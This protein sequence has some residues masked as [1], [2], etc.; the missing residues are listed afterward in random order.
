[1]IQFPRP[2]SPGPAALVCLFVLAFK[3]YAAAEP[4]ASCII[5][6]VHTEISVP[7]STLDR[8]RTELYLAVARH[9]GLL[10][11]SLINT[12]MLLQRKRYIPTIYSSYETAAAEAGRLLKV[13]Y[14]IYAKLRQ[15]DQ[16]WVFETGLLDVKQR[17]VVRHMRGRYT[18]SLDAFIREAPRINVEQLLN[19]DDLFAANE[20]A[21]A[22]KTATQKK[23]TPSVQSHYIEQKTQKSFTMPRMTLPDIAWEEWILNINS[24]FAGRVEAGLRLINQR[25]TDNHSRSFIGS[26]D[27]LPERHPEWHPLLFINLLMQPWLG[28]ELSLNNRL[29]AATITTADG[30]SDGKVCVKGPALSLFVRKHSTPFIYDRHLPLRI[31]AGA[32]I[33]FM[34]SSF[35]YEG[36]WHHGFPLDDSDWRESREMY[37][38]WLEDGAPEWPNQGYQRWMDVDND[39]ALFIDASLITQVAEN[40]W[41]ELYLRRMWI[42]LDV[43]HR[44]TFGGI[45]HRAP[46]K[47]NLPLDNYAFGLGLRYAF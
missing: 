43:T 38:E 37:Q 26:V 30:H 1:M 18:G 5:M 12:E 24:L 2:A 47:G 44:M 6:P 4:T 15:Q 23:V 31:Q 3:L 32:G 36:W 35:K 16:R 33:A 14:V 27:Y 9:P 21:P 8:I 22:R 19:T 29:G 11:Q 13:D 34:K 25:F 20:E 10:P 40:L 42:E 39:N 41:L 46:V 45:P 28:A 17:K 7:D